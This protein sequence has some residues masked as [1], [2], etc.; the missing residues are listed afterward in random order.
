MRSCF[1][2]QAKFQAPRLGRAYVTVE[3]LI[4]AA[5]VAGEVLHLD[6]GLRPHQAD[7]AQQRATHVVGRRAVD[8]NC[9][10]V[11]AYA[12]R[13]GSHGFWC[14][15]GS[16]HVYCPTAHQRPSLTAW[17][18]VFGRIFRELTVLGRLVFIMCVVLA[19]KEGEHAA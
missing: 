16:Y 1:A 11:P 6:L 14:H 8:K 12:C 19:F 18:W 17:W 7:D 13:Q 2:S 10:S 4:K 15:S 3:Q 9:K 5:H